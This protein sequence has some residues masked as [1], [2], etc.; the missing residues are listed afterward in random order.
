MKIIGLTG[1]I[2]SGKSKIS[3]YLKTKGFKI[4]DADLIGKSILED[5]SIKNR[6]VRV[7]GAEIMNKD[8]SIDRKKLG[9]IAFSSKENLEKLNRITLPLLSKKIK[10]RINEY[11]RKKTKLLV[12]D[13]AIL[14]EA[15]WNKIVDEVWVVYINPEVQL[16][17]LIKRENYSIEEAKNRINAQ[18]DINE[19][20]KYADIIINN[21]FDWE[22]TKQQVDEE[23]ERL[24][25][26]ETKLFKN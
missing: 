5:E 7:F 26:Y 1:N 16:D 19:K 9:T 10:K 12:L 6:L 2:A 11:K 8:G 18:M 21:S 23:I 20:I 15:K 4:I 3:E 24:K 17:R 25:S 22:N 14:I 13:A